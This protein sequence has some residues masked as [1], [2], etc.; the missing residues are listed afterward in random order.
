MNSHLIVDD[1]LHLFK[2][3]SI[4]IQTNSVKIFCKLTEEVSDKYDEI[5]GVISLYHALGGGSK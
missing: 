3:F 4:R 2:D 5:E 1:D